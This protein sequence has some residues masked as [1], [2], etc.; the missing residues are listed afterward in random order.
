MQKLETPRR[1]NPP[2]QWVHAPEAFEAIID[3]RQFAQ[4]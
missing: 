1:R 3:P 2:E 4:A